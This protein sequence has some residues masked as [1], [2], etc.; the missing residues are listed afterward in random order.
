MISWLRARRNLQDRLEIEVNFALCHGR[1]GD[2]TCMSRLERD[3]QKSAST[4][5]C[6]ECVLSSWQPITLNDD[7]PRVTVSRATLNSLS[8]TGDTRVD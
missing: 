3:L 5:L 4:T 7:Y 1:D 8:R 6:N 2:W